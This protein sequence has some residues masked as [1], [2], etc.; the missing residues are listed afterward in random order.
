MTMQYLSAEARGKIDSHPARSYTLPGQ[1]YYEPAIFAHEREAIFYRT[2]QLAG[3]V[4]QLA[5]PGDYLTLEVGEESVI[6]LRDGTGELRAFYNVCQHRAHR[7]LE[8]AG[9]LKAVITCPYHA[10]CYG[11]D[12][13]LRA[14]RHSDQVAG[15]DTGAFSL[16]PVRVEELCGFVYVNLDPDAAPLAERLGAFARD[17]LSFDPQPER[18]VRAYRKEIDVRANWKVVIENYDECYHCPVSHPSLSTA[19]LDMPSYRIRVHEAYHVQTSGNC[20]EKQGYSFSTD[21]P[22]GDE[23]AS[24]L[25]WPNTVFEY[26]PG[27]QLTVF[28]NQPIG[29]ERTL[30]VIEWYLPQAQPTRDEQAVIDFVDV[31]REEDIPIVESVQRGLHSRGYRQGRFVVDDEGTGMSE[32][33][34]HDFQLKVLRALGVAPGGVAPGGVTLGAG[35]AD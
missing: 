31:V 28:L 22:R 29:P 17:F 20:G 12:G 34:V 24:W 5:V 13:A 10:W 21:G 19:A 16:Q 1:F 33:A 8:G 3:H 18:L 30:Q 6:V 32:H 25:I 26:Y 35:E 15:F 23:F 27:G 11:L 14:A 7:L 2:W 9:K 4:S